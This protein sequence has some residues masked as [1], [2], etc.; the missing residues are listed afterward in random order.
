[1]RHSAGAHGGRRVKSGATGSGGGATA[2]TYWGAYIRGAQYGV[3]DW[4]S[5]NSTA[6]AS[7]EAE[8]VKPIAVGTFGG[9]WILSN[10]TANTFTVQQAAAD[11]VRAHG[12]IPFVTWGP[13]KS[14]DT[15]N[16]GTFT[17]DQIA[18]HADTTPL[19]TTGWGT[20]GQF[21][22][23]WATDTLAWG[24][25]FFLRFAWEMNGNFGP[26]CDGLNGNALGSYV[27]MWRS[28]YTRFS[29]INPNATWCWCVNHG[30][31]SNGVGNTIETSWPGASYVDWVGVDG[32]NK[33]GTGGSWQTFNTVFS[34]PCGRV[35]ALTASKPFA[36]FEV[37]SIDDPTQPGRKAAW[38]TDMLGS[39]FAPGGPYEYVRLFSWFNDQTYPTVGNPVNL[40][41]DT[42]NLSATSA[43]AGGI[44]ATRYASN[45]FGSLAQGKI[46]PLA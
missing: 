40:E 45:S 21:I 33:T 44:A 16:A 15:P 24:H 25:P 12:A 5:T 32:Y 7:F 4:P 26:W 19:G 1:M 18:N 46:A 23:E 13:Q 20:V 43:F 41:N 2:T 39:Q 17:N 29:A 35:R 31:V 34:N 14:G 27:A 22:D 3:G 30:D 11:R 28:V 42:P 10:N 6:L 8:T 37:G 38:I 9:S 36:V